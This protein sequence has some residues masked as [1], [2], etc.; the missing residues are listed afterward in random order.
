MKTAVYAGSFDLLTNGH[1]WMIQEGSKV[2][3]KLVVAVGDNPTKKPTFSLAARINMIRECTKDLKNVEVTE[4]YGKYLVKYAE[5]VGAQF[6]LRGIRGESDYEQERGMKHVN[7]DLN[8]KI[9]TIFLMPPRNLSEVSSSMVK[10]M[11]G[12]SGW[13]KYIKAYVPAP[14]YQEVIKHYAGK[15]FI[16]AWNALFHSGADLKAYVK[17]G[18]NGWDAVRSLIDRYSEPHRA[19]HNLT[20]ILDCIDELNEFDH[21]Y[22]DDLTG[23]PGLPALDRSKLVLAIWYHDAIYDPKAKDN[24]EKSAEIFTL[25]AQSAG[26]SSEAVRDIGDMILATK[27]HVSEHPNTSILLDIDLSILGRDPVTFAE[28]DA[29]IRAEYDFVP[30]LIYYPKRYEIMQGFLKRP[31]LFITDYFHKKYD[32]Q[33]RT[34][35]STI[36]RFSDSFPIITS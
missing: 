19:Y 20:H 36:K 28:Y 10:S 3:D 26:M 30:R 6:I 21:Q 27:S 7:N 17:R 9:G 14:V 11:I 32:A 5:S 35:L 8:P 16:A 1:L 33:A 2:F 18:D 29:Q 4:F 24:E 31:R 13:H 23:I 25:E 15:D 22:K 34:N 12:P